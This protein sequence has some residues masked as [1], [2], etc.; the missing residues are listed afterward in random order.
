MEKIINIEEQMNANVDLLQIARDYC[1]F[2]IDKSATI[3]FLISLIEIIL[4][5]QKNIVANFDEL[6]FD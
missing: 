4:E 5:N 2:N 1:E 3:G 6:S